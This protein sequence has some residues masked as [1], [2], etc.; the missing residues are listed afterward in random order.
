[1]HMRTILLLMILL[2]TNIVHGQTKKKGSVRKTQNLTAI[3]PTFSWKNL[4]NPEIMKEAKIDSVVFIDDVEPQ[5]VMEPIGC[6]RANPI[7]ERLPDPS[8]LYASTNCYS[9][10]HFIPKALPGGFM[11][12]QIETALIPAACR[13]EQV[14]YYID[15]IMV[16]NAGMQGV[17]DNS[18][19]K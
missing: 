1:M 13:P 4:Y 5:L 18:F 16:R 2:T 19:R 3:T 11:N 10:E 15:G 7:P 8:C 12:K 17:Q 14:V 9:S 6:R